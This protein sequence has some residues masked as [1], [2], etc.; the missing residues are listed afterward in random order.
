MK[1]RF[2][3]DPDTN[4]PH[5]YKHEVKEQEII[6]VF[7]E[8]SYFERIRQDGSFEAIARTDQRR[9][10]RIAFRRTGEEIFIITAYD[11]EDK[12]TI[13]FLEEHYESNR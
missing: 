7:T 3:I 5:V 4:E 11:I 10:L 1:F 9:F 12:E 2:Y 13:A 6:E 8:R